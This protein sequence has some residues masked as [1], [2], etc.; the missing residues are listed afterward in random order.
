MKRT[1]KE[2]AERKA[3]AAEIAA[4]YATVANG[5]RMQEKYGGEWVSSNGPNLSNKLS[6]FRAI[7]APAK[8][9]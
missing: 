2:L 3:A 5:G 8:K 4:M 7:P 1:K 9:Q 6:H